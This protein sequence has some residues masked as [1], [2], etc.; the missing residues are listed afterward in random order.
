MRKNR[1][2]T[3]AVTAICL[4]VLSM[5]AIGF[6][7]LIKL[8]AGAR[9]VTNA[10]DAGVLAVAKRSG[11][12][13]VKLSGTDEI[14]N[15]GDLVDSNGVITLRAYNRV[16]A[17]ALLIG[18]NAREI[19]TPK[20]ME[21]A[22]KVLEIAQTGPNSIGRRL[23][24]LLSPQS[25]KVAPQQLQSA[26]NSVSQANSTRALSGAGPTRQS[27]D[28]FSVA[29]ALRGEESNIYVGDAS[30]LSKLAQYAKGQDVLVR[31]ADGK[32]YLRGYTK[33][34]LGSGLEYQ[35]VSLQPFGQ[36]HLIAKRVFDKNTL[37]PAEDKVPPNSFQS[38]GNAGVDAV[39]VGALA[40]AVA[41]PF[42]Y[43][44][45]PS[46]PTAYIEIFNLPGI[47]PELTQFSAPGADPLFV[48]PLVEGIFLAAGD[49]G[50]PV[51][52]STNAEKLRQ[53]AAYNQDPVANAKP[54]LF[55]G[56]GAPFV[57][58]NTGAPAGPATL[59]Q[60]KGA[61]APTTGCTTL[62]LGGPGYS[63]NCAN[64]AGAFMT[65]YPVPQGFIPGDG[66]LLMAVEKLKENTFIAQQRASARLFQF[67]LSEQDISLCQVITVPGPGQ[68]TGLRRFDR[69]V[70]QIHTT[71]PTAAFSTPGTFIGLLDDLL[72]T[73]GLFPVVA[74]RARQIKPEAT[75]GEI[76]QALNS[77]AIEL[78]EVVYLYM[79]DEKSRR[80][81]VSNK[82]PGNYVKST[83]DGTRFQFPGQTYA[84]L[85]LSINPE[86]DCGSATRLF[87]SPMVDAPVKQ[88][89]ATDSA[90]WQPSSGAYGLL[91][92]VTF[93]HMAFGDTATWCS[94]N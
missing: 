89:F 34:D 12:L 76:Y 9:E 15:F 5:L 62:N 1:G 19:G 20:A 17:R 44:W 64:L 38:A 77:K 92:L 85:G 52:F 71:E 43:Q 3:L 33:I 81:I 10:T 87:N 68:V 36:P 46:L 93:E 8:A 79:T 40:S 84:V 29:Y 50:Q 54:A 23:H 21:N 14:S 70:P 61:A 56:D 75:D 74:A 78:G 37:P 91:G 67:D 32:N 51:A 41:G 58:D 72:Q 47:Q 28:T 26:F 86:H 60:I 88:L 82:P 39:T 57:F 25:A 63:Q 80:L 45:P 73:G 83:P 69:T 65:A 4:S 24:F 42:D 59:S 22:R 30:V 49:N 27:A 66:R 55:D 48:G 94:V 18:L 31:G 53:W 16:V 13:G 35:L 11:E 7:V 2:A 90:Y 6:F